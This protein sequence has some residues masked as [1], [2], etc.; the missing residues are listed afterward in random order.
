M[1]PIVATRT[2]SRIATTRGET[3]SASVKPGSRPSSARKSATAPSRLPMPN[4]ARARISNAEMSAVRLAGIAAG[5]RLEQ[6]DG[7][8]EKRQRLV[9]LERVEQAPPLDQ[10]RR[11]LREHG[12]TERQRS[13]SRQA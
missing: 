5:L 1:E 12:R 3:P 8:V 6:A 13:R 11:L 2:S 7:A 9:V 4:R 10:I